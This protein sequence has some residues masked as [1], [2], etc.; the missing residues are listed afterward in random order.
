MKFAAGM[1]LFSE[2]NQHH[3]STFSSF[4]SHSQRI[5]CPKRHAGGRNARR[6]RQGR[7]PGGDVPSVQLTFVVRSQ[8]LCSAGVELALP[9]PERMSSCGGS[10]VLLRSAALQE[11]DF[12]RAL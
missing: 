8:P 7:Y 3:A 9:R 12:R 4:L 1:A 6:D 2:R 11:T 10:P 5:D